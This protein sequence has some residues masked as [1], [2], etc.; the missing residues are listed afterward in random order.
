MIKARPEDFIV[1]EKTDLP[2]RQQGEYRI[3]QLTKSD[4]NTLDLIQF[5]SRSVTLSLS[6]FS[7]GGK[8][9]RHGLTRQIIAIRSHQ[10]FSREG[11]N[12][13]LRSTGFM[14]RPMGPDLIKGN[15]FTVAIRNLDHP[16][17]IEANAGKVMKT[18]FPN[19]FDD[20]RFRSYDPDRGFFAEKILKRHWNGALQVFLTSVRDDDAKKE[21]QRKQALFENWRDWPAC[22][23]LA[24]GPF[25][26]SVFGYLAVH[27]KNFAAALHLIPKEEVSMLFAAFQSHLWNETL[28][29]LIRMKVDT[30]KE[31]S[32]K[33]GAYLFWQEIDDRALSYLRE[34]EIPTAATKMNFPDDLVRSIYEQILKEKALGPGS[35]RTKALRRVY[36][37]CFRRKA[38]V[39][40][41]DF[42]LFGREEDEIHP[43]K[44]KLT[45]SFFL[46]RGSYATMLIKG[47]TLAWRSIS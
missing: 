20:Q 6:R 34:V 24:Q 12:F 1:E 25:E 15:A 23:S 13:T 31:I 5:L 29:R 8:K 16:D 7:Y 11:T 10:D 46:P 2:L 28:R 22:L 42:R 43:G 36:F 3:Y 40:P 9:D 21:R 4:W 26:K 32:G 14:D 33:E 17:L 38:L 37:R 18:G 44:K 30:V 41:G 19:F 45:V 27:P 39:T 47:L 35:F